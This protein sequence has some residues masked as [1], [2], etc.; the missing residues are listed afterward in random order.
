MLLIICKYYNDII[1]VYDIRRFSECTIIDLYSIVNMNIPSPHL[2]FSGHRNFCNIQDD[3]ID[4][5]ETMSIVCERKVNLKRGTEIEL[6][7]YL[8]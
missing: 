5:L 4:A 2:D 7:I 1:N 3:L 6:Y 8:R